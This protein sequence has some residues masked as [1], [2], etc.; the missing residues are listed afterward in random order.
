M[1]SEKELQ[2]KYGLSKEF[3]ELV[4]KK[5]TY[6]LQD[7]IEKKHVELKLIET[8][9]ELESNILILWQHACYK[10]VTDPKNFFKEKPPSNLIYDVAP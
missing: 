7:S 6:L 5:F 3:L 1:I 2:D 9:Q 8:R 4:K 10:L